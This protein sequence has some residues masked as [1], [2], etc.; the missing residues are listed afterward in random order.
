MKAER[1]LSAILLLQAHG[2]MTG[3]EMSKRLEVSLEPFIATWKR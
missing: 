1:L 2:R 3:R